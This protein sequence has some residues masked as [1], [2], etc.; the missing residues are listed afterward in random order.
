MTKVQFISGDSL[1]PW[2]RQT[3]EN[4][5]IMNDVQYFFNNPEQ[6]CD[7]LV[8]FDSAPHEI[9]TTLPKE[10][11]IFVA[12]EPANVKRYNDEYLNQFG[13]ILT[14][15]RQ[16][17]HPHITYTQVGLPWHIGAYPGIPEKYPN[18]Q[19]FHEFENWLPEKTKLISVICS[20]KAFTPEHRRRLKF[21]ETLK[22]HFGDRLDVFGRGFNEIDDK[23]EALAQYRYHIALENCSYKDYWTEKIADPL[24]SLTYPI[25][26]GCVNL[27]DY[28]PELAF[29]RI[30]ITRPD[31]AL[32]NIEHI[33]NS[34]IDKQNKDAMIYARNIILYKQNLFSI[35]ND[36]IK[37]IENSHPPR[38]HHNAPQDTI[39]PESFFISHAIQ[40][41]SSVRYARARAIIKKNAITE[42]IARTGYL[43]TMRQIDSI[44]SA[45]NTIWRDTKHLYKKKTDLHYRSHIEWIRDDGDKLLRY[46]YP[47]TKNSVVLDVGG[48]KGDWTANIHLR[49][50]PEIYVLEP[51]KKFAEMLSQRFSSNDNIKVYNYGLGSRD[52]EMLISLDDNASSVYK[53][54]SQKSLIELKDIQKFIQDNNLS[55]IDLIKL[56]IEGGEYDVLN[57]LIDTQQIRNIE[58]IQ[59][60]FHLFVP[61]A[62]EQYKNLEKRLSLTHQLTWKYPYVW[63]NWQRKDA[64]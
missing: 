37:D 41:E 45:L 3:P 24:L 60:Q 16:T 56:N 53:N 51:V 46:N 6:A 31:Q 57:R 63:E 2:A 10:R 58:N 8:V 23:T 42:K 5:G 33:I 29:S 25:Y 35:I 26:W 27:G 54:D 7:Y 32:K 12:A 64:S 1:W 55:S 4:D 18:A 36:K 22:E 47:L 28:L 14:T 40:P 44:R 13:H 62:R 43:F 59:V 21:V 34:D 38:G 30:D 11:T 61:G 9:R 49:F 52:E 15:D 17:K 39:K 50:Q 19:K 48:Y 20:N